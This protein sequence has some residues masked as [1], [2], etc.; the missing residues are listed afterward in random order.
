MTAGPTGLPPTPAAGSDS[1]P[2]PPADGP[3]PAK[4]TTGADPARPPTRGPCCLLGCGFGCVFLLLALLVAG[5]VFFWVVDPLITGLRTRPSLPEAP[6]PDREDRWNL[7]DKVRRFAATGTAAPG[8]TLDLTAGEA[9]ALL[10]RWAPIPARG[11]ALDHAWIL[12]ETD[13]AILVLQG[14]GFWMRSLSFAVELAAT[15]PGGPSYKVERLLVNGLQLND[16]WLFALARSHLAA[17]V[18][19]TTGL[20]PTDLE[21]GRLR[22]SF[23][24]GRVVLS[25]DFLHLQPVTKLL[26]PDTQEPVAASAAVP[27]PARPPPEPPEPPTGP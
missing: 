21:G 7:A 4:G 26:E 14:S 9:N 5:V 11:F 3:S 16:G 1:S 13:K 17:W 19:A 15:A 10:Q 12:P 20:S 6:R 8:A 23:G 27:L 18:L 2:S 22:V 25:G 24:P